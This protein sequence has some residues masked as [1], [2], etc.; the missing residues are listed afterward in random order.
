MSNAIERT[1]AILGFSVKDLAA[2]LDVTRPTIYKYLKD[3]ETFIKEEVR[4]RALGLAKL[5]IELEQVFSESPGAMAKNFSR[6]GET[7]FELLS[8]P[9]HD[10]ERILSIAREIE[11]YKAKLAA[12]NSREFHFGTLNDL[13]RSS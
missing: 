1:K 4:D 7:L 9:N 6:E 3:S 8:Q 10:R 5:A 13:T 12:N 2:L 11:S